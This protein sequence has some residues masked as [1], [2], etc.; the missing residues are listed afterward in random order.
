V[1]ALRDGIALLSQRGE[2]TARALRKV[3]PEQLTATVPHAV[4]TLALDAARDGVLERAEATGWRY[5]LGVGTEVMVSADTYPVEN[6]GYQLAQV[7]DGPFVRG[8]AE[9]LAAA[10][11]AAEERVEDYELRLLHIP[12]LYLMAV[13]LHNTREPGQGLFVAIAPTPDGLE[14]NRLYESEELQTQIR[15]LAETVPSL[16]PDDRSGG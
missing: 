9:A 3:R 10:D 11:A 12:A 6:D 8:T 1:A 2:F 15:R 7:T 14:A 16:G 13:W 5:L 4:F